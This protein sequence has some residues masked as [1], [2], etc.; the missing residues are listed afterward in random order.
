MKILSKSFFATL[1]ASIFLVS[2][3]QTTPTV[4]RNSATASPAAIVQSTRNQPTETRFKAYLTGYSYWDNT[5]PGSAAISKPV[6]HSRAGG[7]G[8]YRDPITIA[9]GHTIKGGRQTLDYPAGTRFYIERLRKY[10]IVED[11]CGDGNRPQDGPCHTG[12]LGHAWIDIYVGGRKQ[13]ADVSTACA[14]RITAIQN[15]IIN[16]GPDY[17]VEPGELTDSGC[18]V[19]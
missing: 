2:C 15:V 9:V 13:T 19:F 7:T 17:K 12:H 18:R 1:S 5:P 6:I 8:T 3:M 14:R 11:V 4:S 10:A 16:P